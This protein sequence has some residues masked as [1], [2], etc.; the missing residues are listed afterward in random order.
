MEQSSRHIR[1]CYDA[2]AREYADRFA[3]ELAHKPLDREI[4]G[5][6]ASEVGVQG[7]VIDLGCGPGQTTAYLH[8]GGVRVCGL[9]LSPELVREVRHSHPEI[10]FLV[11]DMLAHAA[12][13]RFPGGCPCLLRHCPS[14]AGRP[15]AG[16]DGD[17]SGAASGGLV[18]LAFHVGE[19]S[20]H[21]DAFLGRAVSLDFVFF[22]PQVVAGELVRAGFAAVEV[23]ERDPYPEVE[24]PAGATT[25]WPTSPRELGC[26]TEG[27]RFFHFFVL[28]ASE[29]RQDR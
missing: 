13:R 15:S 6:F 21:V 17:V 11:A 28:F 9:D 25:S 16:A 10:P 24:Y 3:D 23:I 14:L 22:N 7:T 29:L 27:G 5:R 20:V 1:A 8:G 12:C 26:A 19:G 2:V 18:L 4:L